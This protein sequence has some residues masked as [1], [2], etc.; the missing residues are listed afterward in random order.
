MLHDFAPNPVRGPHELCYLR[1]LVKRS[2]GVGRKNGGT[3]LFCNSIPKVFLF[4][5]SIQTEKR[6]FGG[7]WCK[8]TPT[9]IIILCFCLYLTI[10][11][12][13]LACLVQ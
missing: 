6:K 3:F 12:L 10:L 5:N 1:T 9:K 11:K 4:H 7:D 13:M 2:T 8:A